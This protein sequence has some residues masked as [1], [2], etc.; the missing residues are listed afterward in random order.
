MLPV[1]KTILFSHNMKLG[2][3]FSKIS[4]KKT[5]KICILTSST[6]SKT[7]RLFK[8]QRIAEPPTTCFQNAFILEY[9]CTQKHLILVPQESQTYRCCCVAARNP[10]RCIYHV[11]ITLFSLWET[12]RF[13]CDPKTH[14]NWKW[15]YYWLH[16]SRN[17]WKR[18]SWYFD[19][20][21]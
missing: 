19:L 8:L 17:K 21:K 14:G 12:F 7:N 6:M 3:I 10:C 11:H 18:F 4:L 13:D 9:Y 15:N 5:L 16:R 1:H 2:A 20:I